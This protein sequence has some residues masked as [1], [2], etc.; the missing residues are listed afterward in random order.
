MVSV[1]CTVT[2]TLLVAVSPPPS[3]MV[4]VIEYEP[5]AEKAA[6]LDFAALVP[7]GEKDTGEGPAADQV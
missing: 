5:A 3:V 6:V 4:A 7:L 1:C 2:E